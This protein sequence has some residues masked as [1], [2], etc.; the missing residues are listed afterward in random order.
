MAHRIVVGSLLA[1]V[2]ALPIAACSGSSGSG[3]GGSL[4]ETTAAAANDLSISQNTF[5]PGELTPSVGS[6]TA[7][8]SDLTSIVCHPEL[9]ARTVEYSEALNYHVN[10]FLR[11]VDALLKT[12]A[13]AEDSTMT[14]V[15]EGRDADVQLVLDETSAGVFGVK[16]WIASAGSDQFT[17]VVTGVIDWSNVNDISK[18]LTFDLDALHTVFPAASGDHS[19]G[20]LAVS[21]ERLKNADGSDRKRVVTYALTNFVP[22][23]GDPHGPRT[24]SIDFLD[25]PG[26]GGAM[27]YDASTVFLCPPNPQSVASDATTY[28]RWVVQG[29]MVAGRAD[30]VASGGQML[31]GDRWVGLSCRSNALSA[32]AATTFITDNSYW[33]IKEEDGSGATLVGLQL[34]VQDAVTTDPP[35]NR[36]FGAV[37]DLND[38]RNDPTIPSSLPSNAFPNQF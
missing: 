10:L 21:I 29:G 14:W 35:C 26:V 27:L 5:A 38:D 4:D 32:L 8:G 15:Y 16:L 31:S 37:T 22:V 28:A 11:D 19:A 34:A 17:A 24:G 33:L 12:T 1:A 23:Y 7:P 30:A 25:E 13:T 3:A 6:G 20:Q 2:F 9:F 36:A 18:Q